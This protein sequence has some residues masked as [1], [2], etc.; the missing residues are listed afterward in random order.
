M[1][2][3][4][5]YILIA[6]DDPD[7]LMI[8]G[9][10]FEATYPGIGI[11]PLS[12]GD[13][14]FHFLA[15]RENSLPGLI[16]LDYNMP[17]MKATEVL[18]QLSGICRYRAIP[19]LVWTTSGRAFEIA[20]CLSLGAARVFVKPTNSTELFRIVQDLGDFLDIGVGANSTHPS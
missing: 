14:V 6:D 13:E 1:G 20:K 17:R 7:D 19:K 15:A 9:Q 10:A 4:S 8:F 3:A 18:Q 5:P 12:D 16:V 2:I 11:V